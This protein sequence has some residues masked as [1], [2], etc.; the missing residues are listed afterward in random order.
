MTRGERFDWDGTQK[1]FWGVME[2]NVP[3][4]DCVDG[5]MCISTCQNSLNYTLNR[6]HLLYTI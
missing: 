1:N 6:V 5:Y 2:I 3:Y 4:I